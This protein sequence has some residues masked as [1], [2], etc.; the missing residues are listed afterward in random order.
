MVRAMAAA[1]RD[2]FEWTPAVEAYW[3]TFYILR[4]LLQILSPATAKTGVDIEMVSSCWSSAQVRKAV[5]DSIAQLFAT[6][7]NSFLLTHRNSQ[8]WTSLSDLGG[9]TSEGILEV[10]QG[11][12][13]INAAGAAAA[14]FRPFLVVRNL[15]YIMGHR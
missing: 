8:G 1:V 12:T 3:R 2:K 7:V 13:N 9:H 10:L 6:K 5:V 4:G 14:A 11:T 15:E